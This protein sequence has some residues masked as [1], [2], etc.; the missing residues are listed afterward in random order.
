MQPAAADLPSIDAGNG[1]RRVPVDPLMALA[2]AGVT[3]AVSLFF[4]PRGYQA[5]FVDMAHDGYQLREVLDLHEGAVVFRDT[6]DQYGP[7]G[8]YLNTVGL[9]LFGRGLLS[10]KYFVCLWYA[11]IAG[12]LFVFA[13]QWLDPVLAGFSVMVWLGLAPFSLHGIMISPH[14]YVLFFQ[15]LAAILAVGGASLDPRRFALVGVLT[16]LSW[17]MKQSMGVLFF[18]AVLGYLICRPIVREGGGRARTAAALAA[19]ATGFFGVI[20]VVLALLWI[21]G[22]LPDWYRQTVM[23]PRELY[24]QEYSHRVTGAAPGGRLAGMIPPI[25]AEFVRL[26]TAQAPYWLIIRAAVFAAVLTRVRRR[27]AD[28]RLLLI[29]SITAFLWLGAFPSA[30]FMHQ[31]WTAS[32]AIPPFVWLVQQLTRRIPAVEPIPAVCTMA[33]VL[34]VVGGGIL[35]RKRATAF[36]ASALTETLVEPPM[37]RGIRTDAP[38][39][40][41]F[42]TIYG[43]MSRYRAHHPGARVVSID[44]ADRFWSGINESLLFLSAFDGNSHSQPV[45][46]SLPVLSTSIYP[47]YTEVLWSEIRTDQPLLIEH[48]EG[49][50]KPQHLAAYVLLA[51]VES[52]FGYWYVYGP[53]HADRVRHGEVSLFLA[54]DGSTDV[55]FAET[56][57]PPKVDSGLNPSAAGE[58]R[59]IVSRMGT[60]ITLYT[61][62]ADLP[63]GDPGASIEPLAAPSFRDKIIGQLG[64]G[65][66]IVDGHASGRFERLL[67]FPEQEIAAGATL[68][69]RG[70]LLEGGL[71]VGFVQQDRWTGF[72]AVTQ[73]GPFEAVLEIQ[74]SGR[75]RPLVSN[76]IVSTPW[77]TVRRHWLRGIPGLFTGGFMPNR[78]RIF[79]LGWL[80]R[81]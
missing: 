62:P 9:L 39:K 60:S 48:R 75:Y 57:T 66:W 64:S 25:V 78:F 61:W 80:R 4:A 54:R 38:M 81:G 10:V 5:G 77:Q 51:A 49:G 14:V 13:R 55:G 27:F 41:A 43:V 21:F 53:D 17:A 50:Y 23:F 56:G 67:E 68:L 71:Q 24:L 34:I 70:E 8:G 63:V 45:Y 36:R 59:G 65:M 33:I 40:R 74:R 30:N 76:C 35:E 31:W 6:F 72:I 1:S 15:T 12:T 3:L 20:G 47:R 22:A 29:A 32:L 11:V 42:D 37:L 26:Q 7:G 73:E 2:L 44:A 19:V 69:V 28:D 79:E 52:D 46:W 16:G 58:S 18:A